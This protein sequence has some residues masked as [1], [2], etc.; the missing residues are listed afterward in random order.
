ML[1]PFIC[2][3]LELNTYRFLCVSKNI[4]YSHQLKL[5]LSFKI[6]WAL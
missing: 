1:V 2:I 3:F 6:K 4:F 5:G